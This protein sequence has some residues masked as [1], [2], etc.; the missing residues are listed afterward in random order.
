MATE[1]S[2]FFSTLV[3]LMNR[4]YKSREY[5][6]WGPDMFNKYFRRMQSIPNGVNIPMDTVYAHNCHNVAELLNGSQ[7]RFTDDSIGC[8][9]YG[10]NSIW[11]KFLNETNGGVNNLSNNIISQ[12]IKHASE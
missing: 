8:H 1:N 5:Q 9:W 4:E 7:N 3:D 10:G 11:G 2:Y 12:L 6:C